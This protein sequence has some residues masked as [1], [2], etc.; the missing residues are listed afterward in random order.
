MPTACAGILFLYL[1]FISTVLGSLPLPPVS[2]STRREADRWPQC[3]CPRQGRSHP[4]PPLCRRPPAPAPYARS[5]RTIPRGS[6][7]T[8]TTRSPHPSPGS[9]SD[10]RNG[11]SLQSA[12]SLLA[13]HFPVGT[14]PP[15]AGCSNRR[16]LPSNCSIRAPRQNTPSPP[17]APSAPESHVNVALP[18]PR[19]ATRRFRTSW[20]IT[21]SNPTSIMGKCG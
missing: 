19:I 3:M 11:P 13:R 14:P 21:V 7:G 17:Q 9:A 5:G 2:W 6:S 1:L 20:H 15:P 4:A 18:Y 12:L 10:E 8:T 16:T